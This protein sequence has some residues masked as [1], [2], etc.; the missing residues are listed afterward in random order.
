M[1]CRGQSPIA[2]GGEGPRLDPDRA[3]RYH[4]LRLA[5]FLVGTG[6]GLARTAWFAF[7][8]R[9]AAVRDWAEGVVPDRR[10]AV[11]LYVA[12]ATTGS[13]LAGLPFGFLAGYGVERRFGLTDQ[14]PAGWLGDAAKGL[15]VTLTLQ[16][17]LLTGAYAVIRRRP[18]D[19]WLVLSGAAVPVGVVLSA[20]G[21]VLIAPRFN[22]F[23][24]LPDWALAER[25]RALGERAGVTIADV[26]RV[27]MSRQTKKANAYFTGLGRTKRIVLGDT[28]IGA[29]PP[30]EVEGVVAHELGHQVHGDIWRLVG[31]GAVASFAGAYVAH[32]LAPPLAQR[33]ADRTG[34]RAV[35]D[36]ASL[37]LLG[38]LASLASLVV[39]P[40]FALV[41]RNIERRTDRYALRLT[42]DGRAYASAMRRLGAQ[43]LADPDPP[44]LAVLLGSHPPI[45][46]RIAA[47]EAFAGWHPAAM[48]GE[49]A[50]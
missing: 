33:T 21:P 23:E 34:V 22:R 8:G 18:Q 27:D 12:A 46:E 41:S 50:A 31:L 25:V 38:L 43:N 32:R 36:V 37:P 5:L 11:P 29:F 17:P 4:R 40:L 45:A 47:A 49:G 39:M 28:L 20:L 2:S 26:Y 19:W 3:R 6:G 9:S 15:A 16:V 42:G 13:W 44:R 48:P 35:G 24:P 7:S 1:I 10:L 30:T 14:R